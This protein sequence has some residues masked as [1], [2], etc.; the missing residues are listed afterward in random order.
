M[1][2]ALAQLRGEIAPEACS[3][4][5]E[6]KGPFD[7]CVQ[8][9]KAFGN[10]CAN[11]HYN[12]GG[13]RCSFHRSNDPTSKMFRGFAPVGRRHIA[14]AKTSGKYTAALFTKDQWLEDLRV[15]SAMSEKDREKERDYLNY[16]IRVLFM[17]EEMTANYK[18][19]ILSGTETPLSGGL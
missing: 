11:C 14:L 15:A 9:E 4:C 5:T 7:T 12:S 6:G 13:S 17:V 3:Y 10:A 19:P 16:R 1:E 2:A 8:M 18:Q